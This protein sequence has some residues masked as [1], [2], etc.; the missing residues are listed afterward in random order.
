MDKSAE[1]L[2]LRDNILT[3]LLQ[4]DSLCKFFSKSQMCLKVKSE[5]R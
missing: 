4:F 3:N 2:Q 5:T 1:H